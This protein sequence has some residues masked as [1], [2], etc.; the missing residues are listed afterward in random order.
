MGQSKTELQN[1]SLR[2]ESRREG[3]GQR[4]GQRE[5]VGGGVG[6]CQTGK[7][8][9]PRKRRKNLISNIKNYVKICI[10]QPRYCKRLVRGREEGGGVDI[11]KLLQKESGG[12]AEGKGVCM[13]RVDSPPTQ[14]I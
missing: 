8:P 5:K 12:D 3:E 14:S 6:A 9:R 2:A 4:K 13:R 10:L 7:G 1:A 11:V